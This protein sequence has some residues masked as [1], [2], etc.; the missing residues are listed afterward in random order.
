MCMTR[1]HVLPELHVGHDLDN[2][3]DRRWI[4]CVADK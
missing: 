3:V 1:V 4:L 2:H